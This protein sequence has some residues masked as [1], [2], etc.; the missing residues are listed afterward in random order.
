[1]PHLR[2][3]PGQH[4]GLHHRLFGHGFGWLQRP[5][6]QQRCQKARGLVGIVEKG[7]ERRDLQAER[8]DDLDL[9]VRHGRHIG[10]GRHGPGGKVQVGGRWQTRDGFGQRALGR[11]AVRLGRNDLGRKRLECKCL[12]WNGFRRDGRGRDVFRKGRLGPRWRGLR[13]QL[14]QQRPRRTV[15]G[16]KARQTGAQWRALSRARRQR[17]VAKE[18]QFMRQHPHRLRELTGTR[19]RR[20]RLQHRPVRPHARG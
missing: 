18:Q 5:L 4:L 14:R 11:G 8:P 20:L 15:G 16:R 9:V 2:G 12:G 10:V 6:G 19:G 3:A 17:T 7:V 1:M 13:G